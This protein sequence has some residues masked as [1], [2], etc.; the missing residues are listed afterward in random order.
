MMEGCGKEE[1][2]QIVFRQKEKR[3]KIVHKG[4]G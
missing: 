4:T 3:A 1:N 2:F